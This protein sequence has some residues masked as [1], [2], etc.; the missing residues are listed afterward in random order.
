MEALVL[1]DFRPDLTLILD[2][3]IDLGLKRAAER[4]DIGFHIKN[5]VSDLECSTNRLPIGAQS[6]AL[7]NRRISDDCTRLGRKLNERARFHRLQATSFM[8]R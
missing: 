1:G 4:G 2:L 6:L 5:V 8:R 7:L 3:P